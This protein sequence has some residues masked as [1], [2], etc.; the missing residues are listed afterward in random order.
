LIPNTRL[1]NRVIGKPPKRYLNKVA[2]KEN[3]EPPE[4]E[5]QKSRFFL[6]LEFRFSE[7]N[8]GIQPERSNTE[9]RLKKSL[10]CQPLIFSGGE[11]GILS[12]HP[13]KFSVVMVKRKPNGINGR[14]DEKLFCQCHWEI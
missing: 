8:G 11:G 14:F 5:N 6:C 9:N 12:E 10:H 13:K 1:W 3:F 7:Q 4:Y 2:E